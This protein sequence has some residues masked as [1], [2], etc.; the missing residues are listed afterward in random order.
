MSTGL[1]GGTGLFGQ[2]QTP[3]TGLGGVGTSGAGG[4]LFG[5]Q[6]KVGGGGLFGGQ[7]ATPA[8][9]GGLFGSQAQSGGG[10]FGGG[11][12][13]TLFSQS[14][15]GSSLG[16]T[17]VHLVYNCDSFDLSMCVAYINVLC[18]IRKLVVDGELT[19]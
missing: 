13:G 16:N 3:Q 2:Q 4:G 8:L 10:L 14:N 17:Q 18:F 9:G 5:G 12:G 11:T 1:G 15:I 6:T 19:N 7:S